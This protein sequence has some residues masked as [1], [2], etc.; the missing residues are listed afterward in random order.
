MYGN[1]H[2]YHSSK[3]WFDIEQFEVTMFGLDFAS[4]S[5]MGGAIPDDTLPVGRDVC[6]YNMYVGVCIHIYIIYI[7]MY[8]LCI[9]YIYSNIYI[10]Y[11]YIYIYI[12]YIYIYYIHIYMCTMCI[13]LYIY[14]WNGLNMWLHD[15]T[16]FVLLVLSRCCVSMCIPCLRF[17]SP[18]FGISNS[19]VCVCIYIW[20]NYNISLTWIKT[21]WGWFPLLTM[22]SSEVAVRSL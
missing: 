21:I 12:L 20:A 9:L 6:L 5:D 18:L 16:P 13:H 8:I 14:W 2:M 7:Y 3:V 17:N 22:I 15:I 4:T 10:Y 11:T 19:T 1:P